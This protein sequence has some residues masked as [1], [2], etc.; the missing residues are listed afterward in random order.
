MT[1]CTAWLPEAVV[2]RLRPHQRAGIAFLVQL[3]SGMSASHT[4]R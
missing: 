1:L 3:W 4:D 2:R